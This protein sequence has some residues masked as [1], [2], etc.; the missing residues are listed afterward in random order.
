MAI[1]SQQRIFF[2]NLRLSKLLACDHQVGMIRRDLQYHSFAS[3]RAEGSPKGPEEGDQRGLR[4][5]IED[6]LLNIDKVKGLEF[7]FL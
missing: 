2:R 1:R 6:F 3:K 7:D 5:C 4:H